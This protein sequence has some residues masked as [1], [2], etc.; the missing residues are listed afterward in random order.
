M[1]GY[2]KQLSTKSLRTGTTKLSY[3]QKCYEWV[4]QTELSAKTLRMGTKNRAV[5]KNITTWYKNRAV[6]QNVTNGY[7]NRGV[8]KNI[9]TGYK[10]KTELSAKTL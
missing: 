7:K 2:K 9:T 1:N 4:Q 3:Q 8:G 6:S 10:K 5:C